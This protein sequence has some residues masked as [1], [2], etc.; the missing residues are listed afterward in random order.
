MK[1]SDLFE[2]QGEPGQGKTLRGGAYYKPGFDSDK[3]FLR[4]SVIDWHNS[5]GIEKHH[6]E[7]AL[8]KIKQTDLFKKML[9]AVGLK[10]LEKPASEKRGTLSFVDGTKTNKRGVNS[11]VYKIH[12]N[13]QIRWTN[14]NDGSVSAGWTSPSRSR[15][16]SQKPR[17][18]PADP[19]A[20]LVNIYTDAMEELLAKRKKETK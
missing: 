8:T 20:T 5:L 4:G 11:T 9:P 2:A 14:E 10:Y 1:I 12:G 6:I 15:L 19:V 17:V 18:N 3:G 13:G 7:Q 16:K